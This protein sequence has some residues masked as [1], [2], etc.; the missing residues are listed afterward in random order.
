MNSSRW[1]VTSMKGGLN[2]IKGSSTRKISCMLPPFNG[3]RISKE[4]RVSPLAFWKYSVTFM[5][6]N[7]GRQNY[8]DLN[9]LVSSEEVQMRENSC[10]WLRALSW[11]E[12]VSDSHKNMKKSS[13]F[14]DR[15]LTPRWVDQI[16]PHVQLETFCTEEIEAVLQC[17]CKRGYVVF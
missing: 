2:S 8:K 11:L 3:G 14:V 6:V 12:L 5:R 17:V 4:I 10:N 13:S 7:C 16:D 9:G 15:F 1:Y